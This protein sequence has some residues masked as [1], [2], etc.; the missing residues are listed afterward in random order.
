MR[1]LSFAL[2]ITFSILVTGCFDNGPRRQPVTGLVT[3]DGK[4]LQEGS[5]LFTPL[6]DGSTAGCSI[7]DG[8]YELTTENGPIAGRYSVA[9]KAWKQS[10][11]AYV[12][13]ATGE[14]E[15]GLVSIIPKRYNDNTE[16]AAEISAEGENKIDFEL[17]SK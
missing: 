13:E 3:M 7:T 1:F 5:I 14:T 2:V 6:G 12:D 4:P 11:A 9:I 15:S 10:G 16:L 8:K 17:T